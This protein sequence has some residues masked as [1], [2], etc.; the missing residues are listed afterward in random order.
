MTSVAVVTADVIGPKMAGPAIRAS[1]LARVL[2][3]DGHLTSLISTQRVDPLPGVEF[4]VR[5]AR[6][7][8]ELTAA[9]ADSEVV[10]FQGSLLSDHGWLTRSDKLLVA[11]LYDPIHLEQLQAHQSAPLTERLAEHDLVGEV[12]RRQLRRGDFFICA[13]EKQRDFWLGHLAA[14]GRV[15]P[16]QYDKDESLRSLVDVVPFGLPSQ[17]PVADRRPLRADGLGLGG[18][19][20]VLLWAGG[21]YPWFDPATLLHAFEVAHRS[22]PSLKLVFL[23]GRHPNPD[24]PDMPTRRATIALAEELG[25]R[26]DGV[27]FI[28]EWIDYDD[29]HNFLL[30]ADVGVSTHLPHVETAFSFRTRILD[31]F[32][33]GLPVVCTE[34]DYM[35]DLVSSRSLGA[36]VP[37]ADVAAL[38]DVLIR[39]ADAEWRAGCADAVA[40]VRRQFHWPEATRVLRDFCRS[41]ERAPDLVRGRARLGFAAPVRPARATR[42]DLSRRQLRRVAEVAREG[43]IRSV[44]SKVVKKVRRI[45]DALVR[46]SS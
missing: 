8:H 43:G 33:A 37:H 20:V 18:D 30:D 21:L 23:A 9:L 17:P 31:Y 34:G 32:W 42:S 12:L 15:N 19:D 27:H 39:A 7:R 29:R 38:A 45:G 4:E 44:G 11:D 46:S 26:G 6:S 22:C 1:E 2:A 24:V 16:R 3:A 13:S 14:E 25:L 35:A 10:V 28:E 36:A 40:T 5:A 41:P